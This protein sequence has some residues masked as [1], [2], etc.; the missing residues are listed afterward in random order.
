MVS[1][2]FLV[3]LFLALLLPT[4]S[5]L[6]SVIENLTS[7]SGQNRQISFSYQNPGNIIKLK[8]NYSCTGIGNVT[9]TKKGA[10]RNRDYGGP[11]DFFAFSEKVE[12]VIDYGGGGFQLLYLDIIC[13]GQMDVQIVDERLD[14]SLWW[15]IIIPLIFAVPFLIVLVSKLICYWVEDSKKTNSEEV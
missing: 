7:F 5:A 9:I 15:L 2:S 11:E 10:D 14:Y 12:K 8:G 1:K 13:D 6:V 3:I 4:I